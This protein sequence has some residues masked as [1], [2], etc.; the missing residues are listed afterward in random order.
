MVGPPDSSP[1]A[2]SDQSVDQL[3]NHE[4]KGYGAQGVD[5]Q[6]EDE[7]HP[8]AMESKAWSTSTWNPPAY[9]QVILKKRITSHHLN[10]A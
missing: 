2:G 5:L 4:G 7:V 1:V 6:E 10:L 8:E 9:C 3:H